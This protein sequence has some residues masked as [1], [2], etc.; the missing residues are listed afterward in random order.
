MSDG[1]STPPSGVAAARL[2]R[3][4]ME[5]ARA[6]LDGIAAFPTDGN[7]F[8]WRGSVDGPSGSPYAGLEF[9]ILMDFPES[10]PYAPPT[11]HFTTPC[12]HPN[13]SLRTGAVCLDV[14]SEQWSAVLT[15]PSVLLSLQ[16]LLNEPNTKSPLNAEAATLWGDH[17][18]VAARAQACAHPNA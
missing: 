17:A 8:Q 6:G 18:A 1:S 11:I 4:V 5:V 12:F 14:L 2:Q 10:Y 13:I 16:S 15:V 9:S 7:L 3:E